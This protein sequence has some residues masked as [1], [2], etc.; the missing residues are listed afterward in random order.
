M[1]S[2]E[3]ELKLVKLEERIR[4]SRLETLCNLIIKS[5]ISFKDLSLFS[6]ME[7]DGTAWTLF[8]TPGSDSP[9]EKKLFD[10][11]CN[12]PNVPN[13]YQYCQYRLLKD[14]LGWWG[15][16]ELK[17]GKGDYYLMIT[18]DLKIIKIEEAFLPEQIK[19]LKR[20]EK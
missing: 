15:I 18:N 7:K 5:N 9:E 8:I 14:D 10:L 17:K 13:F 11:Y 19:Y 1:Y 20:I 12:N 2:R 16:V 6:V 3:N 4:C